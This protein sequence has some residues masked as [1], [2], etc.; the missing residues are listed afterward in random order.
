MAGALFGDGGVIL[1]APM[2]KRKEPAKNP[3]AVALGRLGGSK[4]TDKPKGLAGVTPEKRAEIRAAAL[5]KRRANKARS[6]DK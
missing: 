3:N 6:A 5:A 2:A 1:I 4:R